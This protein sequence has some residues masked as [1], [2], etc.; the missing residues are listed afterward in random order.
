MGR[1]PSQAQMES[2]YHSV[3]NNPGRR[4]AF[5]ARLLGL[6]R[7]QVTRT[8]PAMEEHGYHLSEDERGG[9]WPFRQQR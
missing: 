5:I 9:L 7:S 1:K 4:P 2:I 8:L 3:E 6:P